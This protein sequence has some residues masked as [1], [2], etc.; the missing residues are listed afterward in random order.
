MQVNP[1]IKP[2]PR[3][4]VTTY[5][6]QHCTFT[7]CFS[8]TESAARLA[9]FAGT[10]AALT[11]SAI[12]YLAG[13]EK[14]EYPH[15]EDTLTIF[16]AG[17]VA[18]I[19]AT[20]LFAEAAAEEHADLR[21]ALDSFC[22]SVVLALAM[23]YVFLGI[24]QLMYDHNFAHVSTFVSRIARWLVGPAVFGFL[25]AT[26]VNTWG[27]NLAESDAWGSPLGCTCVGLAGAFLIYLVLLS[28]IESLHKLVGGLEPRQW[29]QWS[30][31]LVALAAALV[32]VWSEKGRTAPV[33]AGVYI[34]V[35]IALFIS[36]AIYCTLLASLIRPPQEHRARERAEHQADGSRT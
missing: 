21:A 27:L 28:R 35:M 32:L 19:F 22:A 24:S 31:T 30:L 33:P 17:L 11:F 10:L 13:R 1:A 18:L 8:L 5:P 29:A 36:L 34:A 15:L 20:Y 23:L 14:G 26:A 2:I 25:S 16:C 4:S 6:S 9:P 12:I 3:L 7:H